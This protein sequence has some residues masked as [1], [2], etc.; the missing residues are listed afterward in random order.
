MD[1]AKVTRLYTGADGEAHF[2]DLKYPLDQPLGSVMASV[3]MKATSILFLTTSN[4][5]SFGWHPAPRRQ[6]L[7]WTQGKVEIEIGDGSKRIIGVGD[8]LLAEDTTGR[9]HITRSIGAEPQQA[10]VI[11]VD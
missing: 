7:I 3:R 11:T 9:G 1:V 5:Q 10:V 4:W 8:V 6:Y 2:E